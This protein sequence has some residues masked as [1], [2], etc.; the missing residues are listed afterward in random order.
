MHPADEIRGT[1]SSILSGKRLVLAVTGSIAAVETIR[2]AREFIRHGADVIPVMTKAATKILHPDSL[3]FATGHRPIVELS[4]DTEHI[5]YC[6][7]VKDPVDAVL[8]CPCTANTISKIALGIDDTAVTT[9]VTT[10]LGSGIPIVIVPAMHASM[11]DH[12]IVQENIKKCQD[13]SILFIEPR[14]EG[15]QA[16]IAEQELIVGTVIK[17]V[18]EN[19]LKDKKILIIGGGTAEPIDEVRHL[20]NKSSGKMALALA[21][22]AFYKGAK[23][24][25]W[26]GIGSESVPSYL[27][28]QKFHSLADLQQCI[29]SSNM[30]KYDGI[31]ICAALADYIPDKQQGKLSSEK[32]QL[33]LTCSPAPRIIPQLQ[34]KAPNASIIAFK[35]ETTQEQA[36][37]RAKELLKHYHLCAVIANT[38]QAFGQE[39]STIWIVSEAGSIIKKTGKKI[40]L[41]ADIVQLFKKR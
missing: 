4:G 21:R 39:K 34:K 8:V 28:V 9:F 13:Q 19:S 36:Q 37:T 23:V 41:A 40:D 25:L 32:K 14:Q 11:L 38:T 12:Q 3:W 31:I 7:R 27:K 15:E 35:L 16:K 2:L 17:E 5:Q 20:T 33:T 29:A 6:G 1:S 24:T 22:Q 18:G 10:A 30:K 26:Y